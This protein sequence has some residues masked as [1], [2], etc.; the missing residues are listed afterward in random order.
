[1]NEWN[2]GSALKQR[3]TTHPETDPVVLNSLCT[4]QQ[5]S[6]R[7]YHPSFLHW[8]LQNKKPFQCIPI[9]EPDPY[10]PHSHHHVELL[11][12]KEHEKQLPRRCHI[13][14]QEFWSSRPQMAHIWTEK[15][16]H[17]TVQELLSWKYQHKLE[18]GNYPKSQ[19]LIPLPS[20][21]EK[22]A[23]GESLPSST[24]MKYNVQFFARWKLKYALSGQE[25]WPQLLWQDRNKHSKMKKS[26]PFL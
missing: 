15:I 1:M 13:D 5:M 24:V 10:S 25:A 22:W 6:P 9:H 20:T 12:S 23:A 11:T 18:L 26:N 2:S 4:Q 21:V 7:K 17:V 19:W 8:K 16:S 14:F 3:K